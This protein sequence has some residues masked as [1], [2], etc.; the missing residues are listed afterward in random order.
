MR[1]GVGETRERRNGDKHQKDL[2]HFLFPFLGLH[3][4]AGV[5]ANFHVL[6]TGQHR[7]K[8]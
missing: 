3:H 5:T 1:Y 7:R 4:S 6:F 8:P 2:L